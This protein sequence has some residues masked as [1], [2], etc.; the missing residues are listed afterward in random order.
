VITTVI[1]WVG[2]VILR[3]R[4]IGETGRIVLGN[5]PKRKEH[6]LGKN[7]KFNWDKVF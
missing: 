7:K 3:R 4:A 2:A 6:V 1:Y 5:Y